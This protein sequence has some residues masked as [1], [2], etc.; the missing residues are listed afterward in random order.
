MRAIHF[1]LAALAVATSKAA[2]TECDPGET[3]N[4]VDGSL[5]VKN[6]VTPVA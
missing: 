1:L 3:F 5:C 6:P 4:A 2:I